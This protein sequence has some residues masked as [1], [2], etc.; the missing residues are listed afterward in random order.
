M[1]KLM[2]FSEKGQLGPTEACCHV[3]KDLLVLRVESG[4]TLELHSSGFRESWQPRQKKLN[5]LRG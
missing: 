5:F 4:A 1:K 3:V 2:G